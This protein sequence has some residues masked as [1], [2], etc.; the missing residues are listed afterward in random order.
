MSKPKIVIIIVIAA[1]AVLGL[2]YYY[3]QQGFID[4]FPTAQDREINRALEID[5]SKFS[6]AEGLSEEAF[7]A[8]IEELKQQKDVVKDNPD[9]ANA[10]LRFGNLKEFLNDHEGAIVAWKQ[11]V[12]VQSVNFIAVLNIANNY[13]YF[14]KDLPKAE[15][16]YRRALEIDKSLTQGYQGLIDLYRFN[17]KEK[18]GELEQLLID[19]ANNDAPNAVA[20]L[21]LLVETQLQDGRIEQARGYL[22]QLEQQDPE[23]AEKL[24]E[25]H[26]EL[27]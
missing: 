22:A 24:R 15:E 10:W 2:L 16:Y 14:I 8:K 12:R 4:I 23:A 21:R 26:G 19:G 11:T 6:A 27:Q 3:Q 13:Q 9:D 18:R 20:Y 17:W 7:N 1:A 25:E 5:E